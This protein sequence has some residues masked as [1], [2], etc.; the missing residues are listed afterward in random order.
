MSSSYELEQKT[1]SVGIRVLLLSVKC[2]VLL[3]EVQW[4]GNVSAAVVELPQL[5][6]LGSHIAGNVYFQQSAF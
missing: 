6:T 1:A 3:Y 2:K 5:L 4:L